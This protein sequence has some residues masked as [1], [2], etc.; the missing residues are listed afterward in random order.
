MESTVDAFRRAI[1]TGGRRVLLGVTLA[2]GVLTAVGVAAGSDPAEV[3][4]AA[5]ADPVQS[6]MSVVVPSFGI[7]LVRD[8]RRAPDSIRLIPTLLGAVLL[9]V[10]I[11]AAGVLFCVATLAFAETGTDPW[12]HAG[13]VAVGSLLVQAVAALVGTG[14][15]L[16]LRSRI[17]AYLVSIALPLGLWALLGAVEALEPAQAWLTPYATVRNLLSGEMSPLKWAQWFVVL[18]LWGVGLN[19]AGAARLRRVSAAAQ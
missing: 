13:T 14:L 18:L 4:F 10:L 3:T 2:L 17:V 11:G 7:L 9:A 8:L 6:I 16:L 12:R 5:L 19:V 1:G 15:G